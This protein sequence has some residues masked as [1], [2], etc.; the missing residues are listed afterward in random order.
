MNMVDFRD[1]PYA[2]PDVEALKAAYRDTTKKLKDAQSYE[3]ARSA[4]FALQDEEE[5]RATMAVLCSV[6]NTIDTTDPFYEGE[7]KWLRTENASL[8]PLGKA[9]RQ[10]LAESPSGRISR[11]SSA[12]R[13]SGSSTRG[14]RPATS[15]SSRI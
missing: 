15:G 13:C 11:R 8:I 1:M 2:R 12:S 7:M 5:R 14:S 9:Y 4:F 10:A 3:Q 6:R